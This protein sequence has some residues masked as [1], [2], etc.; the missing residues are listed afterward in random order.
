MFS[1]ALLL[2]EVL[3]SGGE[4]FNL[5]NYK[6]PRLGVVLIVSST[7]LLRLCGEISR[8]PGTYL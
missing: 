2:L 6:A 4:H 5:A 7:L 8:S 3:V 1:P